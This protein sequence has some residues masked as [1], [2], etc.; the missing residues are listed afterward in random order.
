MNT[1]NVG[2]VEQFSLVDYPDKI[3]ATIFMQGCPWRCPFCHNASLQPAGID[4]H[5]LWDKFLA[6][7]STRKKLL[8][9]VVFSGGEPLMQDELSAAITEV[10]SLG[11]KIGLHTGG[12]RPKMLEKVIPLVDWVGFDIKAPLEEERYKQATGGINHLPHVIE[13]LNLLLDSNIHFECRTTCDPRIL[14][15]PDIL[16]IG[17]YLQ[18]K[19]V[20]E[21]YL[22]KYRPIP[23]D[24]T[25]EDADCEKFFDSPELLSWL[26]SNFIKF[27]VR[28]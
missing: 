8:D 5:F 13:S 9:A 10:K 21:Y 28:K 27:D 15:L 18:N 14:D 26:K 11:F 19:G 2:G 24:T 4:T 1:I 12:Y 17:K 23:T 16:Q 7:L 20:K 6:F 3:A 25:T 22:Q